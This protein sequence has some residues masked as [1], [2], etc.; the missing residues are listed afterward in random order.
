MPQQ[1]QF[2]DQNYQKDR[3]NTNTRTSMV[4]RFEINNQHLKTRYGNGNQSIANDT[5]DRTGMNSGFLYQCLMASPCTDDT[6]SPP[7]GCE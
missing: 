3:Y 6:P 7:L 4:Y 1:L 5:L 2:I